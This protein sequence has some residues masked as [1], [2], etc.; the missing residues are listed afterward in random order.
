MT[1]LRKNKKGHQHTN[2]NN[3]WVENKTHWYSIDKTSGNDSSKIKRFGEYLDWCSYNRFILGGDF[4][5]S[6]EYLRPI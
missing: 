5:N 2:G 4:N 1:Q 3:V 6:V